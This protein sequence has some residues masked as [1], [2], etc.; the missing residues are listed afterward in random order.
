MS[1]NTVAEQDYR[2]KL[3]EDESYVS[4]CVEKNR[5]TD[6][7]HAAIGVFCITLKDQ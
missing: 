5:I 6:E 7:P 2:A 3:K 1:F 4:K